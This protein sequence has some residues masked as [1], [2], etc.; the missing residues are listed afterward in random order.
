MWQVSNC[1]LIEYH[2]EPFRL[3]L[4]INIQQDGC[5]CHKNIRLAHGSLSPTA[6]NY[7]QVISSHK[8]L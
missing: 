7:K 3:I 8:E 5:I 2:L 6:E 4:S 1:S